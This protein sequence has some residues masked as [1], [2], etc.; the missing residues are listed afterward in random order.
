MI[1]SLKPQSS[2]DCLPPLIISYSPLESV[3]SYYKYLGLIMNRALSW[4]IIYSTTA[5]KAKCLLG[6]IFRNFYFHSSSSTL[7]A[8]YKT[9]IQP[10]LEYGCAIWDPVSPSTSYILEGVQFFALKLISKSSS[11]SSLFSLLKIDPLY[12]RRKRIKL[13]LFFKISKNYVSCSLLTT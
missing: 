5:K 4:D 2:F 7:M 11:Y 6:L 3:Y 13:A 9:I 8:L 1:F 12:Q 10:V